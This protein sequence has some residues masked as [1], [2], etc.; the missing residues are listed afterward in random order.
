MSAIRI[1]RESFDRF[2]GPL[3]ISDANAKDAV[4]RPDQSGIIRTE[5]L[6]L[7]LFVRNG[8]AARPPL[9]VLVI[10]RIDGEI[11]TI[12]A[13]L[14]V[15]PDLFDGA[16]NAAPLDLLRAVAE[17]FGMTVTVAGLPGKIFVMQRV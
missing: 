3:H 7:R 8:V 11:T 1:D 13:A 6:E 17:R 2:A 10:A 16:E 5:G 15:Y 14:K 12:V 9:F 4:A